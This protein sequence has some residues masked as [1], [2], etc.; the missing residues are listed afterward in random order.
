[1]PPFDFNRFLGK[2]LIH[3]SDALT[4]DAKLHG[5]RVNVQD[6]DAPKDIDVERDR[7]TVRVDADF[8]IKEIHVG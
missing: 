4:A 8:K 7:L 5:L 2:T 3:V 1:M 6:P